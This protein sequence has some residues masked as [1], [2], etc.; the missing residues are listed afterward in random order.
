MGVESLRNDAD[1]VPTCDFGSCRLGKTGVKLFST[2]AFHPFVLVIQ[3]F[4]VGG[5]CL[6]S[7]PSLCH[8][9]LWEKSGQSVCSSQSVSQASGGLR[10]ETCENRWGFYE[11]PLVDRAE[12]P[13]LVLSRESNLQRAIT[14]YSRRRWPASLLDALTKVAPEVAPYSRWVNIED[15]EGQPVGG[16]ALTASELLCIEHQATGATRCSGAWA[17]FEWVLTNPEAWSQLAP[18]D[19]LALELVH[20][21]VTVPRVPQRHYEFEGFSFSFSRVY[22][23]RNYFLKRRHPLRESA[24]EELVFTAVEWFFKDFSNNT[25]DLFRWPPPG[26]AVPS[27]FSYGDP[28]S[29]LIYGPISLI[30]S[31][32]WSKGKMPDWRALT[33]TPMEMMDSLFLWPQGTFAKPAFQSSAARARLKR[34]RD[35]YFPGEQHFVSPHGVVLRSDIMEVRAAVLKQSNLLNPAV[36][37]DP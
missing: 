25:D 30:E 13:W 14:E 29:V 8:S 28:K 18:V 31:H 4:V 6:G 1:S 26:F 23:F 34:L 3:A 17:D 19:P 21:G 9:A 2:P 27:I 24:R 36:V 7:T 35:R 15:P 32:A 5:V 37:P 33:A 20:E 10:V 12:P 22:E 11:G 16:L